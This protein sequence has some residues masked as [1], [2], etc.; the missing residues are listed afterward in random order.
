MVVTSTSTLTD[1]ADRL[2]R[3]L[4]YLEGDPQVGAPGLGRLGGVVRFRG[5][6]THLGGVPVGMA[7]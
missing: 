4:Q 3:A 5:V 1:P 7:M 2:T 6:T